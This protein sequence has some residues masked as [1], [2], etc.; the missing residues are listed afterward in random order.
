VEHGKSTSLTV[1]GALHELG[2]NNDLRVA[3]ISETATQSQK[4]LNQ[5][6]N[7]I[8]YNEL[9]RDLYPNVRPDPSGMW[10]QKAITIGRSPHARLT[11]K[12]PSVQA[13]GVQGS[14]LGTRLDLAILDD[15]INPESESPAARRAVIDWFLE[16]LVG[17]MVEG[18]RIWIPG[19]AWYEDDLPH[20]LAK[21]RPGQFHVATYQ[22]GTPSCSWPERWPQHR[23][24]ERRA[25]LGEVEYARQM[26]NIPLGEATHYFPMDGV[27]W[28]Q[29]AH[30]D[31][32]DWWV[33]GY[34][35]QAQ[36]PF[37]WT[38][39]GVDLGASRESTSS[40]TAIAVVGIKAGA[41]TKHLLHLRSG[42]WVGA[43]LLRQVV[44][45]HRL[46]RPKEWVVESNA[47]QL[48][49]TELL[50]S[51]GV[52]QSMGATRDE[53]S[54]VRVAAQY[55]GENKQHALWGIRA[56]APEFEAHQWRLPRGRAEVQEL[57]AEMR[58]YTPLTHTGD[59]LIAL[60]LADSRIRTRGGTLALAVRAQ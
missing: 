20:W 5:V 49:M 45:V 55:T 41:K 35:E 39:A 1:L 8:L 40:L 36:D 54:T 13:L 51:A 50:R 23:L 32:D 30:D 27:S 7:N 57:I 28:C 37:L 4:W 47:A 21:E 3:L 59:R 53:V 19:T 17:R 24:D 6:K 25:I 11:Q 44:E 34:R 9:Y 10:H 22:A 14:L 12:D 15:V 43:E 60:W 38:A 58:R 31:P 33:G 46:L 2:Q 52:L 29:T 48:H 42:H 18:G 16:I 26:L 56:L